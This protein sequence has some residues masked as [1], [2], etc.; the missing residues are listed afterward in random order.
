MDTQSHPPG[1][2]LLCNPF[3]VQGGE[4]RPGGKPWEHAQPKTVMGK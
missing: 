3:A 1:R 4:A 2:V